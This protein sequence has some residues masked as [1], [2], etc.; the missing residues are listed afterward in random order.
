MKRRILIT[1]A[2]GMVGSHMCERALELGFEVLGTY[3]HPTTNI[4]EIDKRV[5]L[6]EL[7]LRDTE[8]VM[9]TIGDFRPDIIEHMG[10]QSFP[11]E[12]WKD[13]FY[14][15]DTNVRG[16]AAILEKVRLLKQKD[17][18]DPAIVIASSSAI[19]GEGLELAGKE[20]VSEDTPMLP[21]HP[22]GVSKVGQDLLGFQYN[23]NYGLRT[24]RARL[25]N[26]TGP[27][28]K[29]SVSADFTRRAVLLEKDGWKS[30]KLRVGNLKTRRAIIDVHDTVEALLLLADKGTYGEAYN[31]SADNI[32]PMSYVIETIEKIMG[33]KFELETD[34][35]LFRPA[36]EK[37]YAGD[38]SKLKR[39]TGW[40]PKVS[41][42]QTISSMIEYWR[43][44]L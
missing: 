25:F 13:P 33:V 38:S 22:Y 1:G 37:L 35:S 19:Y 7:D 4:E 6:M 5:T 40:A 8:K 24:I 44:T 3:F 21:L 26:T 30:H 39:D 9:K 20:Q 41:F 29:Q 36:D 14:T 2:G 17:G 10:A 27:K 42:E 16:T 18:Y 28:Q 34:M 23:R 15:L 12:S 31:I 43:K 32:Y 11:T